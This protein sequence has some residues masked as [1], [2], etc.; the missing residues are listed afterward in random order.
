M[1][2]LPINELKAVS[3]GCNYILRPVGPNVEDRRIGLCQDSEAIFRI[4]FKSNPS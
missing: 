1:K 3:G 2:E 4:E